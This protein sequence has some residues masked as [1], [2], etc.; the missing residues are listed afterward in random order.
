[1]S[2]LQEIVA[3]TQPNKVQDHNEELVQLQWFDPPV[4]IIYNKTDRTFTV[5][6]GKASPSNLIAGKLTSKL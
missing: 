2:T 4:S 3:I 1:M 6:V 5:L